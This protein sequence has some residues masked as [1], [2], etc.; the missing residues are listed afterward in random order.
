MSLYQMQ[1]FLYDI[2][3]DPRV[4]QAVSRATCRRSS[5]SYELTAEE[6]AA[7][8][9]GDI[10]LIYVLGANGQLLMHYAA[11][12]GMPWADYIAAMRDGVARARAGARRHLRHDHRHGR[13]GRRRMSLVFAGICSHAPGITGRA[14]PG[15]CRVCA[16]FLRRLSRAWRE[17]LAAARPDALIVVAAEH[18]AN[19][20][21]N[22]M[23]SLRRRHG[24]PL[25]GTDRG[26]GVAAHR[27]RPASPAMRRCRSG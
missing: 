18:F 5:S 25:R 17:Q 16:E 4:Q 12:L 6:R 19:F 24:G 21:M 2:N 23:P 9:A 10:G 3:R 15:R 22:N 13:K 14:A 1:K 27:A 20:F 11:F 26:S 8:S 7:I